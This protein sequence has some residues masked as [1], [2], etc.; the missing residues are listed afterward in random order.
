MQI[1]VVAPLNLEQL[2]FRNIAAISKE[3]QSTPPRCFNLPASVARL[4]HPASLTQR[5][6]FRLMFMELL[7][8]QV[9]KGGSTAPSKMI[10]RVSEGNP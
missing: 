2:L 9:L 8:I 5:P 7:D 10:L 1:L 6:Y 4:K 3:E